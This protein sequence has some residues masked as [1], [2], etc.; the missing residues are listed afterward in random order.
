M[1][2]EYKKTSYESIYEWAGKN[3]GTCFYCKKDKEVKTELVGKK[4]I[5]HDCAAE[6]ELGHLGCDRHYIAT[7]APVFNHRDEALGWF[8]SFGLKIVFTDVIDADGEVYIYDCINDEEKYNKLKEQMNKGGII[9]Y[10]YDLVQ[11]SNK[12][13]IRPD[14]SYHIVY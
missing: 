8:R 5:C 7:I 13:E 14:G 6:F 11:S 10:D 2:F 3:E 1:S 12:L 4:G 9:A